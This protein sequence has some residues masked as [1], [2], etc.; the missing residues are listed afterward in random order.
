MSIYDSSQTQTTPCFCCGFELNML[1][2]FLF[3]FALRFSRSEPTTTLI[4]C[5]L[6]TASRVINFFHWLFRQTFTT[7]ILTLSA[8]FMGLS[9]LFAVGIYV[10]GVLYPKCIVG[11][12]FSQTQYF[13][14]AFILSWTTLSTCVRSFSF[15]FISKCV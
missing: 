12:D 3:S 2:V 5:F 4:F 15:P 10:Y 14:D 8:C 11:V 7:V 9:L 1:Y 6:F 13:T